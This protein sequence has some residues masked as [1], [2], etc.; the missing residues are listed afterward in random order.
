[1][2][3]AIDIIDFHLKTEVLPTAYENV[4]SAYIKFISEEQETALNHY[5]SEDTEE[6]S[7]SLDYTIAKEIEN[8]GY[9]IA[10]IIEKT[11]YDEDA[12]FTVFTYELNES[13][14]NYADLFEKEKSI[15][16]KLKLPENNTLLELI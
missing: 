9:T 1:M 15:N 13:V 16:L 2:L 12:K 7:F 14:Q 5:I 3:D 10:N 4:S 8:F 6:L 11:I